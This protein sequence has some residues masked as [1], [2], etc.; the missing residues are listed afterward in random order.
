M[1]RVLG[2]LVVRLVGPIR[3][4]RHWHRAT[5]E[6]EAVDDTDFRP[7]ISLRIGAAGDM[8]VR[9]SCHAETEGV[10]ALLFLEF[11]TVLVSFADIGPIGFR[12]RIAGEQFIVDFEICPLVI[13]GKIRMGF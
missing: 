12:H 13:R 11:E 6:W 8:A 3:D 9:G 2:G 10:E 1:L 5:L 7:E 4:A